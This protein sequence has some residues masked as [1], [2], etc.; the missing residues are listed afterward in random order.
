MAEIDYIVITVS[1][2]DLLAEVVCEDDDQ[3]LE[4]IAV[5]DHPERDTTEP[6]LP[7]TP[8]ADH[9]W[10]PDE[11]KRQRP[12]DQPAEPRSAH[13]LHFS[14]MVVRGTTCR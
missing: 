6:R 8:Q 7:Q 14:R 2:F 10:E 4:I 5:S 3:L 12:P 13:V 9:S 1:S 11:H